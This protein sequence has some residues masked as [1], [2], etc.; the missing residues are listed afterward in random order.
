MVLE[1]KCKNL[2][3]HLL[4]QHESVKAC[5]LVSGC[6]KVLMLTMHHQLYP[7][8]AWFNRSNISHILSPFQHDLAAGET[9][10]TRVP[11]L[12]NP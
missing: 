9:F 3:F 4:C 5:H 12:L 1:Q 2:S 8:Q 7:N 11:I 10:L 6:L